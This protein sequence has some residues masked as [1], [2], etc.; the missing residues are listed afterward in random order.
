MGCRFGG[1]SC[2]HS[3]MG[4]LSI[5]TFNILVDIYKLSSRWDQFT[6]LPGVHEQTICG[7]FSD[8]ALLLLPAGTLCSRGP[9]PH[10]PK[11][12]SFWS[13]SKLLPECSSSSYPPC[14]SHH[15]FKSCPCFKAHLC[16]LCNA[17][18]SCHP[19]NF[20]RAIG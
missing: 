15:M 11:N 17:H 12:I 18:G 1:L 19:L 20:A 2:N 5:W 4:S 6:P 13:S 7:V 10:L 16:H 3:P 9:S 8:W 14:P